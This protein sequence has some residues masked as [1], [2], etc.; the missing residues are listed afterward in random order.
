MHWSKVEGWFSESDVKFVSEICELIQNGMIVE[1]GVFR[2]RSTCA[3]L[4][5]AVKNKCTYFAIDN[6][7]GGIDADTPASKIQRSQGDQVCKEFYQNISDIEGHKDF[8]M[9]LRED[10]VTAANEF[11]SSNKID[12]CFIDGDHNVDSFQKDLEA[13][14]PKVKNGGIL[15]GHD[16]NMVGKIAEQF[17]NEK[18][19][20]FTSCGNCWRIDKNENN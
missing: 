13:W 16:Y 11:F 7:F 12:F 3:M 9:L 2:G 14:Y 10:S 4:P 20:K 17:A 15:A 8:F 18:R 5:I 1:I 19:S 6:F